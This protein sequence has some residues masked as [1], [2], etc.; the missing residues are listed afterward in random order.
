M[1]HWDSGHEAWEGA[2]V[3]AVAALGSWGTFIVK[4][5]SMLSWLCGLW[6]PRASLSFLRLLLVTWSCPCSA[7]QGRK[8]R[9]E[10]TS[11][12]VCFD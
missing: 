9:E 3:S 8:A 5:V 12:A 6:G 4:T 11:G 2:S 1:Q 10:L 7:V